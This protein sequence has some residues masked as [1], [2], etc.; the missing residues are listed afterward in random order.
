MPKRVVAPQGQLKQYS[1]SPIYNNNH[2][3][4]ES[5]NNSKE[6]DEPEI[7]GISCSTNSNNDGNNGCCWNI[8]TYHSNSMSNEYEITQT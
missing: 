1:A 6:K 7:I 5:N 4:N 2:I 3:K 8:K